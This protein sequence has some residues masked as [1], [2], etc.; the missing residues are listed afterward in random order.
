M[1]GSF[2]GNV[3]QF[4]GDDTLRGQ[5]IRVRFRWTEIDTPTPK[6][7]QAYSP[8]GGKTWETNWVMHFTRAA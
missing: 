6:W 1:R 3:G 8:D 4:E 2:S 5:P 7:E